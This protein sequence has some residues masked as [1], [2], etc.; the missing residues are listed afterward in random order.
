MM[1]T[2]RNTKSHAFN[3]EK[4]PNSS[5]SAMFDL[6]MIE[7][8][9]KSLN[10]DAQPTHATL[11]I[12]T[13]NYL[14]NFLCKHLI[15]P[16]VLYTC[17]SFK[18]AQY[19]IQNSIIDH[20]VMEV[21]TLD[22]N[23]LEALNFIYQVQTKHPD[24]RITVFTETRNRYLLQVLRSFPRINIVSKYEAMPELIHAVQA[25]WEEEPFYSQYIIDLMFDIARPDAFS[26]IEWTVLNALAKSIPAQDV[27][28][29]INKSYHTLFYYIKKIDKKLHI[30]SKGEHVKMLQALNSNPLKNTVVPYIDRFN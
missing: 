1:C 26:E 14:V 24:M 2:L 25:C 21:F 7:N 23:A 10:R 8:S 19:R 12:D 20:I 11:I 28:K 3:S 27:A 16:L 22:E 15:N 13:D 6:V 9:V 18:E 5:A 4:Q 30:K 29:I 17:P